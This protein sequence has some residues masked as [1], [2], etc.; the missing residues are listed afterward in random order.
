MLRHTPYAKEELIYKSTTNVNTRKVQERGV[1][2]ARM[3]EKKK[4]SSLPTCMLSYLYV[5][6]VSILG[7]QNIYTLKDSKKAFDTASDRRIKLV[8][9]LPVINYSLR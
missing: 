5:R 7:F 4:Q 1:S 9:T 2:N 3:T 6:V 8:S